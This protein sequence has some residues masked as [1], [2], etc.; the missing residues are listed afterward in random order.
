[1][2]PK[3]A[4]KFWSSC[5]STPVL[6]I[7]ILTNI[8]DFLAFSSV[9]CAL[10]H[11]FSIASS[12]EPPPNSHICQVEKPWYEMLTF[13]C[14]GVGIP[15]YSIWLHELPPTHC[16]T[17]PS[18]EHWKRR[19]SKVSL[20]APKTSFQVSSLGATGET[21]LSMSLG[22]FF[23]HWLRFG[24]MAYVTAWLRRLTVWS[25]K[26]EDWCPD[27][28]IRINSSRGQQSLPKGFFYSVRPP[29]SWSA[30][31]MSGIF[32]PSLLPKWSLAKNLGY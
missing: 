18:L 23:W 14:V 7:Q 32:E 13:T 25:V 31:N 2:F 20:C 16:T 27:L 1:M 8:P 29:N 4:S 24:K 6:E 17:H 28:G 26:V 9:W 5:L 15:T 19:V 10:N 21:W 3:Q 30:T 11:L 22:L 12:R